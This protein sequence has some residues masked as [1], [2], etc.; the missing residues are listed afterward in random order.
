MKLSHTYFWS[1]VLDL[2]SK[3][4][5]TQPALAEKLNI[6]LASLKDYIYKGRFPAMDVTITIAE[7][8]NVSIDWLCGRDELSTDALLVA[9]KYDSLVDKPE[10]KK[11]ILALT[12]LT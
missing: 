5:L 11:A 1:K 4:S 9:K 7:F 10:I 2:A 8:F 3:Q 12:D 6:P